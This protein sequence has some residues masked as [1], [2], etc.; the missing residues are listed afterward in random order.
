MDNITDE[1]TDL[2][3]DNNILS[4]NDDIVG[5]VSKHSAETLVSVNGN[6]YYFIKLPHKVIYVHVCMTK[7]SSYA[8]ALDVCVHELTQD[9]SLRDLAFNTVCVHV[10]VFGNVC[11]MVLF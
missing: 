7:Y 2:I 10:M 9:M 11:D 8:L 3:T 4:D 1:L 6:I 5:V